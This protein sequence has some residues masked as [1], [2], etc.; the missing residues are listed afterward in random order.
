M[1]K[2]EHCPN[3]H[4]SKFHIFARFPAKICFLTD[5]GNRIS[6]NHVSIDFLFFE[7]NCVSEIIILKGCGAFWYRG[8]FT[9]DV[10]I[11]KMIAS[12]KKAQILFLNMYILY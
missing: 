11:K 8:E 6:K 5:V 4:F 2:F 12:L 7:D 10:T 9:I 3:G 1:L